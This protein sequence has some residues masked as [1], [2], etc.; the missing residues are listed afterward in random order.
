MPSPIASAG[1]EAVPESKPSESSWDLIDPVEVEV[2]MLLVE[3][4][5]LDLLEVLVASLVAS[6]IFCQS[7]LDSIVKNFGRPE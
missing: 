3:V 2:D 7:G 5:P 1:R 6:N 4:S